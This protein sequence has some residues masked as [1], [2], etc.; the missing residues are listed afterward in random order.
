MK[1][2]YLF[3]TILLV[4]VS[5]CRNEVEIGVRKND[6]SGITKRVIDRGSTIDS[7]FDSRGGLR[8]II[9]Y[10]FHDTLL[11]KKVSH[12]KNG[13]QDS[14]MLNFYPNG[15]LKSKRFFFLGK[16]CFE[17]FDYDDTGKV[18]SY[19]FLSSD[20][21]K[22]YV[23]LYD[24]NGEC[25]SIRGS[26]F[27]ESFMY[28]SADQVFSTTDTITTIFYAPNP[29]DCYVKLYTVQNQ[30]EVNNIRPLSSGFIYRVKMYPLEKGRYEW[31]IKMKLFDKKTDTIIYSSESMKIFYEVR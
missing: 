13:V 8:E 2:I 3:I 7:V 26:P 17:R 21:K 22:L 31:Y 9:E 25:I 14:V 27:F 5:A 4:T 18:S 6:L 16:E 12:F 24:S 20:Q 28:S 23:R 30:T 11:K 10:S 29:P 19:V 15:K 1:V